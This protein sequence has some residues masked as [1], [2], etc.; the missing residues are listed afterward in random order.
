MRVGFWLHGSTAELD[1]AY[2]AVRGSH[3]RTLEIIGCCH[4]EQLPVRINTIFARRNFHDVDPMIE[5]LTRLDVDLWNVFFF[6]RR[7]G[8]RRAK[9][10]LPTSMSKS[11][12][13]FTPRP[14]WFLSTSRP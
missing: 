3:R 4:E 9:C 10:L 5:L 6:V 13:S 7:R 14:R 11:S 8:N 2:W 12:P 1:D